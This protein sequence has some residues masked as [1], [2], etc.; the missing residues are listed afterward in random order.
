MRRIVSRK[1][2]AGV[3]G[4][5]VLAGGGVAAAL[6]ATGPNGGPPS[7]QAF[8][9]D[10]AGRLDVSPGALTSAVRAAL[11]DRID[12][13]VAAGRLTA[14]QGAALEQRVARRGGVRTLRGRALDRANLAG[15]ARVVATYLGIGVPTLRSDLASGQTLAQIAS[16]TPGKSTAGLQ[17]ALMAAATKRLGRALAAGRITS[18]QEQRALSALANRLPAVLERNVS[19]LAGRR[20]SLRRVF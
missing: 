8:V 3:A 18:A 17:S 15:A 14:A 5:A 12:A 16:S 13:A 20:F 4:L 2:A 6:A 9:N 1:V 7:R 19:A 11:D 10:V